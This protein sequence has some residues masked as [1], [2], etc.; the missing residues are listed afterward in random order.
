MLAGK[1]FD[2]LDPTLSVDPHYLPTEKVEVA[3][4]VAAV[5]ELVSADARLEVQVIARSTLTLLAYVADE[6]PFDASL[7]FKVDGNFVTVELHK[8]MSPSGIVEELERQLPAG[9]EAAAR[10]H[11]QSEV[12]I[13]TVLRP[14]NV[15]E[16]PEVRFLSSD[17]QQQFRWA[18][19][20]KLRIE[21]RAARG[22]S[23]R[24]HLEL[25]LEGY[26]VRLPL[27]GGDFPLSTGMRL[28]KALPGNYTA[29]IELPMVAGGEV[30][31]TILRRR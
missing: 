5:V 24:S 3:P 19:K 30:T 13:V 17:P 10:D 23:M 16:N 1:Q 25:Y 9:Y 4:A 20:N 27:S 26:R 28:R 31:L 2:S 12:L 11:S 6:G 22:L 8:G 29:L 14:K 21:G 18:G 7:A 15:S